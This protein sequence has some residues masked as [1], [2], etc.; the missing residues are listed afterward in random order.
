MSYAIG[1]CHVPAAVLLHEPRS[2]SVD[3]NAEDYSAERPVPPAD[4]TA[5]NSIHLAPGW[6]YGHAFFIQFGTAGTRNGTPIRSNAFSKNNFIHL[7]E[8]QMK[9]VVQ[10]PPVGL[11]NLRALMDVIWRHRQNQLNEWN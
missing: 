5:A 7:E 11:W 8:D 9:N 3:K 6:R 1:R 2:R 10:V 4:V